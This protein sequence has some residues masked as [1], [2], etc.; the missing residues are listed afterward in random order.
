VFTEALQFNTCLNRKISI[1]VAGDIRNCP[2]TPISYGN[3]QTMTL[4]Q[5]VGKESFK[6]LWAINKDRVDVCKDCE[7]RY[8]CIDCRAHLSDP[9]N[10]FSKPAK[11]RYDPYNAMWE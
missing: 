9:S 8:M 3:S 6:K 2:S 7:F 1:D 4:N 10:V 11:C 5:A